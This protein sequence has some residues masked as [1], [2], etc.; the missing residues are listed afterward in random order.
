MSEWY[1]SQKKPSSDFRMSL[2]GRIDKGNP[3]RAELTKEETSIGR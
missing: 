2:Q 1:D 3:R